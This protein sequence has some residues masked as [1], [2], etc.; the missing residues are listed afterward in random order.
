MVIAHRGDW[1]E[2]DHP[3]PQNSLAAV[4]GALAAGADGAEVDARL[5]ADGAVVLHHDADVGLPDVQQG[6]TAPLGTPLCD[7]AGSELAHL[8]T[9]RGLLGAVEHWADKTR[10]RSRPVVLNIE[11][12]DLPGEP[13]WDSG[14]A[15]AREVA[16][17]LL[18]R[19]V[20]NR[21]T[22]TASMPGAPA[23]PQPPAGPQVVSPLQVIVSSFDPACLEPFRRRA[24]G[25][26]TAL[27]LSDEDDWRSRLAGY[28]DGLQAINPDE[29][30]AQPELFAQASA[31]H[32][33]VVPWTV[34]DPERAVRLAS[35]GAAGLITNRPRAVTAALRGGRTPGPLTNSSDCPFGPPPW[36]GFEPLPMDAIAT[37]A[38]VRA[39]P[40]PGCDGVRRRP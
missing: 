18:A 21:P 25:L 19:G 24:P 7:V 13:G 11:L 5:T 10:E 4:L 38:G 16:N 36:A 40:A 29:A 31:R 1:L 27:L 8:C 26:A 6:C 22:V 35:L 23:W 28:A 12:K 15:L 30:L 3:A 34:D 9:L 37:R 32:L 2:G 33:A 17:I 20:G 39:H 14:H